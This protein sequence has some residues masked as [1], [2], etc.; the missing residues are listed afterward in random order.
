MLTTGGRRTRTSSYLAYLDSPCGMSAPIRAVRRAAH[1]HGAIVD[2]VLRRARQANRRVIRRDREPQGWLATRTA[3]GGSATCSTSSLAS[4]YG[5]GVVWEQYSVSDAFRERIAGERL[6]QRVR[7]RRQPDG[8]RSRIRWRRSMRRVGPAR[9]QILAKLPQVQ[10]RSARR[11]RLDEDGTSRGHDALCLGDGRPDRLEGLRGAARERGLRSAQ[12]QD[13]EDGASDRR[14]RR[15]RDRALDPARAPARAPDQAAA[16]GG[17]G[18]RRGSLRRAD[19]ARPAGRA[20]S[21]RHRLQPDGRTRAGADRRPGAQRG[22]AHQGAGGRLPAQVRV[23]RQHEPRA[24]HAAERD[25]RLL[26]GLEAE[27]VRPGEREAGRVPGRHPLLGRPPARADQRH[28]RPVQGRGRPGGARARAVLPPRG[29]GARGGHGQGARDEERRAARARARPRRRPRGRRR[30]PHP[31]GRLQPA[32]QRGQVHPVR[33]ARGR[34]H[35][36][37]RTAR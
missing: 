20:G 18:D 33:R 2:S 22:R 15:G 32:L 8:C 13:L 12:R 6:G 4:N 11:R 35:R 7:L 23:P 3:A 27:A 17:R 37:T 29:T 10:R 9:R 1:G 14:L 21:A 36:E 5:G 25:R 16:G 31:P 28:P 26:P 34:L 30:A 24:A 19:R